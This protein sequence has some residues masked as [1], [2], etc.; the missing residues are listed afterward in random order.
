MLT[1]QL[2]WSPSKNTQQEKR[3]GDAMLIWCKSARLYGLRPAEGLAPLA[4]FPRSRGDQPGAPGR[5]RAA[6]PG[7]VLGAGGLP[8]CRGLPGAARGSSPRCCRSPLPF[9]PN[10]LKIFEGFTLAALCMFRITEHVGNFNKKWFI[11]SN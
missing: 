11:D 1:S 3:S 10:L 5:R 2:E 8:G 6:E 7:G 9:D 4:A